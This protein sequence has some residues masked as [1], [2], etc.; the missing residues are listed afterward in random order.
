MVS[1]CVPGFRGRSRWKVR[2]GWD[3]GRCESGNQ[4]VKGIFWV[5]SWA[6]TKSRVAGTET[7]CLLNPFPSFDVLT[8]VASITSTT[9][10][11]PLHSSTSLPRVS[12]GRQVC[13]PR[14]C[15]SVLA[16]F[17]CSDPWSQLKY[18][19]SPPRAVGSGKV[20]GW[21]VRHPTPRRSWVRVVVERW[22]PQSQGSST[23]GVAVGYVHSPRL[24]YPSP[25]LCPSLWDPPFG[26]HRHLSSLLAH[27][28]RPYGVRYRVPRD[29]VPKIPRVI[30]CSVK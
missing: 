25:I 30:A 17:G 18:V 5:G 10:L 14:P 16:I 21:K 3:P 8:G 28:P 2:K 29:T 20:R 1:R 6:T 9:L 23:E 13:Y 27:L 4:Y 7:S 26:T 24:W 19:M 11:A 22:E 12:G 15:P